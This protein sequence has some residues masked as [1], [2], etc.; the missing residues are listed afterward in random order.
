MLIQ[1][2]YKY[3]L[4][5]NKAQIELFKQFAGCCRVVWNKALA[6][7]KHYLFTLFAKRRKE[8][9]VN[10]NSKIKVNRIKYKYINKG[11]TKW[12]NDDKTKWLFDTP[13]QCEQATIRDLDR[14]LKDYLFNKEKGFPKFKGRTNKLAFK[15][16]QGIEFDETEFKVRFPK[17]G[18]IRIYKDRPPIGDIKNATISKR[19][20]Y[21]Y[22]S[23]QTEREVPDPPINELNPV[24]IDV[25]IA[26]FAT[27]SDGT[28]FEPLNAFKKHLR[29]LQIESRRLD[30]KEK[31]SSNW[32]KQK[33]KVAQVH[34][35]VA[36]ARNWFL[37]QVSRE[38]A[39]KSGLVKL[40]KLQIDNMSASAKGTEEAPGKN[41]KAKAKLNQSI[42]DQGWHT[43]SLFLEYKLVEKGGRIEFVN[44]PYTSQTCSQCGYKDAENRKAK[45]FACKKCGFEADAD[46]NAAINILAGKSLVTAPGEIT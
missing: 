15:T 2:G 34:E 28:S 9:S 19:G 37:H 24:G 44:A 21:W 36:N 11:L 27:L 13:I 14:A 18:W 1:R 39:N 33:I 43:F 16:F 26:T 8:I 12:R 42:L 6:K 31:F 3:R 41:V 25:G 29:R 32:F 5:P 40:E 10:G 38:I 7:Q 23:I 4:K 20:K 22:I 35:R 30:R 17:I 45:I 46:F